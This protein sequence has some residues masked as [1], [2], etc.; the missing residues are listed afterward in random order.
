MAAV[1]P[2]KSEL[3]FEHLSFYLVELIIF[4]WRAEVTKITPNIKIHATN[5]LPQLFLTFI[6]S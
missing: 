4:K 3:L 1:H 6:R 2:S 5:I